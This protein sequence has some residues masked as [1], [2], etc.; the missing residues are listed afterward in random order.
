MRLRPYQQKAVASALQ[1]LEH[2]R[3]TLLVMPTGTGKTQCF[4]ELISQWPGRVLVLAH[5]TELV[6]QAR[7]RI[8]QMTGEWVDVEQRDQTAYNARIV[9]G[10]MATVAQT[11]RL[12]RL[13]RE[14]FTLVVIDEAHRGACNSYRKILSWFE[15]AKVLGVTATPD[16]GDGKALGDV[17]ESVAYKMDILEAIDD[18]W[19][20]PV[21]AQRIFLDDIDVSG[22]KTSGG[23]LQIG[24]LDEAMVKAT[25]GVARETCAI[26]GPDDGQGVVFFPGVESGMLATE[27]LNKERPDS[28]RFVC[29]QT[30]VSERDQMFRD[31]ASG[32]FQFLVNVMV[33]TEGWDCPPAKWCVM[34]R[35]TKSR[36][37]YTQCVGRV[38]RPLPGV[39]DGPASASERKASIAASGK[40]ACTILDF[41]GNTGRHDVCT[42]VDVLGGSYSDAEI[43]QAKRKSSEGDR[44]SVTDALAN[45][46]KQLQAIAARHQ[47]RVRARRERADAFRASEDD[48]PSPKW[49]EG[50]ATEAQVQYLRKL[51]VRH[52]PEISKRQ[53][54]ALIEKHSKNR[55]ATPKQIYALRR[56]AVVSDDLPFT[57]ARRALDYVFKQRDNGMR[58]DPSQVAR[59]LGHQ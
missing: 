19:L 24:Q 49:R 16:R 25:A 6:R 43:K 7:D 21:E 8:S 15:D 44:V 40:P 46:R 11:R 47:A 23:D 55:K 54:S 50:G 31:Y 22:V 29:G 10:S 42:P 26:V 14:A 28:A 59:L 51:G 3:S 17:F 58:V 53:A 27:W 5:R 32:H 33:A 36:A 45:A 52:T 1:R 38:T 4:G 41:A 35:P 9:V 56:H 37:L 2:D 34:A 13:G 18:G 12:E 30:D 57:V 20:V 39:V 48:S